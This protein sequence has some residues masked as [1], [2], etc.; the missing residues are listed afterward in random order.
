MLFILEYR[1]RCLVNDKSGSPGMYIPSRAPWNIGSAFVTQVNIL[2]QN[3][4]FLTVVWEAAREKCKGGKGPGAGQHSK[5]MIREVIIVCPAH[6]RSQRQHRLWQPIMV[7]SNPLTPIATI[8]VII[9][10]Q[11]QP[12]LNAQIW[13][14]HFYNLCDVHFLRVSLWINVHKIG[15]ENRGGKGAPWD[16]G[17]GLRTIPFL[18]FSSVSEWSSDGCAV[19]LS[20]VK[21]GTV[22]LIFV[23]APRLEYTAIQIKKTSWRTVQ[24][25]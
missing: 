7:L 4:R 9:Q 11:P 15:F 22:V 8:C 20:G 13:S 5:K 14:T 19:G 17:A 1:P 18:C 6:R 16:S 23:W 10:V 2:Y 3:T 24:C 12:N 21:G 25:L